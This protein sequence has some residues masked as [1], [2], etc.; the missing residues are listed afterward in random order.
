M[1]KKYQTSLSVLLYKG[2]KSSM[3]MEVHFKKSLV[4]VMYDALYCLFKK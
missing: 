4:F 1:M 2:L 3:F